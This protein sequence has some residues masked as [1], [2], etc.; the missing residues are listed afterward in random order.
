MSN[1]T[2]LDDPE[3]LKE[4]YLKYSSIRAMARALDCHHS[5][6]MEK[7]SRQGVDWRKLQKG[8]VEYLDRTPEPT[9]TELDEFENKLIEFQR[10]AQ[11][12]DTRQTETSLGI[13]DDRPIGLGFWGDW[14]LGHQGTDYERFLAD[15]EL[16]LKTEGLYVAGAGD[17]KDNAIALSPKGAS[18]E[19]IVRPGIQDLIVLKHMRRCQEKFLWLVKGC[20]DTWSQKSEDRDFVAECARDE[21]AQ[22]VNLWHGGRVTLRVG[23]TFYTVAAS[24]KYRY[25]SSLNTTNSQRRQTE[26]EGPADIVAQ[27]HLHYPDYHERFHMGQHM[28]FLRSGTYKRLDDWTQQQVR[29]EGVPGV[30]MAI[31]WPHRKRMVGFFDFRDG[32]EYLEMVRKCG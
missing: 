19:S 1:H 3:K 27:A 24:H 6:V 18:H 4:L 31:L 2:I 11:K 14:H 10:S 21:N 26:V 23:E 17:Y 8:A 12:L 32:I 5:T 20:H 9:Q 30:P 7:M 28:I 15:E 22:A 25:N 13:D 29:K 16:I